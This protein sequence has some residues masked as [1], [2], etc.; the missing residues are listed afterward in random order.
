MSAP[1]RGCTRMEDVWRLDSVQVLRQ[2][3]GTRCR[4]WALGGSCAMQQVN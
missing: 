1:A 3:N 4:Q 2:C